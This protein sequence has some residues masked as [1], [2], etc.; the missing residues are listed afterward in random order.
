MQLVPWAALVVLVG[1]L[2]VHAG[3]PGCTRLVRT[4]AMLVLVTSMFGVLEHALVNYDSGPLDQRYAD[5]WD[6]LCPWLRWRYAIT[7]TVGPAP[8]LAPGMLG[9]ASA[10][11]LLATIGARPASTEVAARRHRRHPDPSRFPGL[12]CARGDTLVAAAATGAARQ[13]NEFAPNR[14]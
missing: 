6:M 13:V 9:Q 8:T 11:L 1:A 2:V 4:L 10:T 12:T 3:R 14:H 5:T 7:S